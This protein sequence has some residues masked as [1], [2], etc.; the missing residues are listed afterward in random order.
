M[1]WVYLCSG[2]WSALWKMADHFASQKRFSYVWLKGGFFVCVSAL[3]MVTPH[4]IS[5][6]I[7]KGTRFS[8]DLGALW[9]H[10]FF[11]GWWLTLT[12]RFVCCFEILNIINL[13]FDCNMWTLVGKV[14]C[15]ER[16][17]LPLTGWLLEVLGGRLEG[18]PGERLGESSDSS[19]ALSG[20]FRFSTAGWYPGACIINGA[21][22]D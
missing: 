9:V 11:G 6:L 21:W 17:R 20:K 18:G 5:T 13:L 1:R 22:D 10:L 8:R 16:E 7:I 2:W 19:L 14:T 15:K 12:L 3:L 4:D